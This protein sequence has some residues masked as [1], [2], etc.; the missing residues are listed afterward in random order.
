[1]Q[2]GAEYRGRAALELPPSRGRTPRLS[3][4]RRPVLRARQRR[5]ELVHQQVA[6]PARASPRLRLPVARLDRLIQVLH[7]Q[8]ADALQLAVGKP[9]TLVPTAPAASLD[10]G[11]A[12]RRSDPPPGARGGRP[13]LGPAARRRRGRDLP[14]PLAERPGDRGAHAGRRLVRWSRSGPAGS[15]AGAPP[16]RAGGRSAAELAEARAAMDDLFRLLVDAGASDLHLRTGEPPLLRHNGELARQDRPAIS[17]ERLETMLCSIMTPREIG[18]FRETGDTDWA[19]EIA[20]PRPVPLQ[21]RPGP[22][23]AD[24]RVPGHPDH[25]AHRRRDGPEPRGAEPLLSHQGPRRRHRSHRL[26]QE[27]DARRAGGPDQPDPHRPHH[28]HRRPDRVRAPEQEVPGDPAPGAASTPARSSRRS[29]RRC[30]R[31][32]TSSWW[33]R[34][35]TSR[36]SRSPSRPPRPGTWCS[37]RCTPRRPRPP[38]TA[39]STSSRPTGRAQVRVMLSESLRGVIA[40]TLCK[41]IGGGRVAAREIL[42][43][44]S[45][46]LEP[47][48]RGQDVPDPV[49]DADQPAGRAWSPSTTR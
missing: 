31:I 37:A 15:R 11:A 24:R 2:G 3:Q 18:E 22:A 10:Q 27:H 4:R 46:G 7:E 33:A 44:D 43:T 41:K 14:V 1:M 47:D 39:S 38:S 21:R 35:A 13:G 48:P 5:R 8:R 26:G 32:R 45:G 16:R 17:A 36:R 29:G 40:Q 19:Y 6:R 9:A 42:L 12:D 20:G 23:R 28:H 34:C 49:G 25:R 30:G